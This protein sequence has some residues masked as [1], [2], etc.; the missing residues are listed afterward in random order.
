MMETITASSTCIFRLLVTM[1]LDGAF[2][3]SDVGKLG[4][5]CGKQAMTSSLFSHICSLVDSPMILWARRKF[6]QTHTAILFHIK[7]AL[8]RIQWCLVVRLRIS[9]NSMPHLTP[10]VN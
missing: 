8:C 9:T 6:G 10:S 3:F 5:L 2:K 7:G 1:V 4:Y